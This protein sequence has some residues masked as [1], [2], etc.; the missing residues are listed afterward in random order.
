[1]S[2]ARRKGAPGKADFLFSRIVRSRGRCEYPGCTSQGPFDTAHLIGRRYSATRC[3]EDNAVSSCRS[4][5]VLIDSW[6]DEKRYVVQATCGEDRY[7]ELKAI[8]EAGH[9]LSAA[10]FWQDEVERLTARCVELDID[11]RRNVA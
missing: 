5:H 6:W 11:T 1:M 7:V 9:P 2:V 10:L 8:A 4:H 3:M